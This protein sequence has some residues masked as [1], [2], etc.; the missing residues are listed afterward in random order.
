MK[1]HFVYYVITGQKKYFSYTDA[2][3][4]LRVAKII[5]EYVLFNK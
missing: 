2:L 5:E 4:S 1:N 3:K